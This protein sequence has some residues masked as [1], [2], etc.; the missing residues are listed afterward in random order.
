[1]TASTAS[2]RLQIRNEAG[3]KNCYEVDLDISDHL[4]AK[5]TLA[6]PENEGQPWSLLGLYAVA[7]QVVLPKFGLVLGA[8]YPRRCR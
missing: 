4:P 3:E 5:E 8:G 7:L 2:R 1:M 6:R